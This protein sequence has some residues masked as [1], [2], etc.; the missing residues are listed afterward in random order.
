ME[1]ALFWIGFAIIVGVGAAARGRSALGWAI[2]GLVISPLLALVLLL[3]L[4]N[5]KTAPGTPTPETHV[6]CPDCRELVL[7]D[8]RRC[9]H[10]GITLIPQT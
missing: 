6:R 7:K 9:K 10:C 2:L 5:R 3:L 4:P 1:I 8:A